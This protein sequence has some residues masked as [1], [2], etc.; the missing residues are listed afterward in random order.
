[1]ILLSAFILESERFKRIT[2]NSYEDLPEQA[3]WI[4]IIEPTDEESRWIKT[5]YHQPLPHESEIESLEATSRFYVDNGGI[6]INTFFLHD[7]EELPQN[8]NVAFILNNNRLF[9]IHELELTTF[10]LFRLR[11]RR[12]RFDHVNIPHTI[13]LGLFQ[14]KI[15]H[16]AD[17][18]EEMYATLERISKKVLVEADKDMES[19]ITELAKQEDLIGKVRLS[20]LDQQRILSALQRHRGF[21]ERLVQDLRDILQDIDSLSPHISFLFDKIDF[22]MDF[23]LSL[24]NIQQN[25]IIKIFSVAAVIFLPPTLVASIY[26]MN[27]EFIPELHWLGG[28]PFSLFLMILAGLLPYWYFKRRGWL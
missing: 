21:D 27:F 12:Q 13:L 3:V 16:V 7:F 20:I 19:T 1:M 10:R 9:T 8:V 4:D 15:D 6:H 26:G 5:Y 11:A 28:Y 2:I 22:L 14:A 18:I 17:V 25:K 23:V 24:V